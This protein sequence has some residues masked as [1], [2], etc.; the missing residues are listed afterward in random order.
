MHR[1]VVVPLALLLVTPPVLA[2]E[3][4][5]KARGPVEAV[6]PTRGRLVIRTPDDQALE[7]RL[8]ERTRLER[9][10]K[11]LEFGRLEQ[12]ARVR[13]TYE[14]EGPVRRLVTLK[15]RPGGTDGAKADGELLREL[16]RFGYEQR[17]R[18]H[19]QLEEVIDDID[20]GIADLRRKARVAAAVARPEIERRIDDLRRKREALRDR[21]DR[22][23][24]GGADGWEDIKRGIHEAI[25][26]LRRG[27]NDPAPP[28]PPPVVP[29]PPR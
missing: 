3:K 2:A 8:T 5:E 11:P 13:V 21:V 9:G 10:N 25:E 27:L 18:Y 14:Q 6:D 12:G 1:T 17:D 16:R 26:D 23:K 4:L 20:D 24:S 29:P 15:A 19:E 28:P 7:F 22:I